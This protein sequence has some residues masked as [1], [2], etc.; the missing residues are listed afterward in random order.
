[1]TDPVT[2]VDNTPPP[3]PGA[4]G[5]EARQWALFVHLSALLGFIIPFGNLVGPL[6]MVLH[7]LPGKTE[8]RTPI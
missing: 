6:I 8:T 5:P 1:M 2:Q 7:G 3:P 4:P